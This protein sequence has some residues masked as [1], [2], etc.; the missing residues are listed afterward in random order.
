M[1]SVF[2]YPLNP[3]PATTPPVVG[4]DEFKATANGVHLPPV[5][6]LA[7]AIFVDYDFISKA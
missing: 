5:A 4:S 7:L 3:S 1:K 6:T 2:K